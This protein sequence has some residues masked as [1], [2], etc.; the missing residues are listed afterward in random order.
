MDVCELQGRY[1]NVPQCPTLV[2]VSV[3]FVSI[4][5]Q[6]T[7]MLRKFNPVKCYFHELIGVTHYYQKTIK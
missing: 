4:F 3:S 2:V 1:S 6:I 5:A 7:F